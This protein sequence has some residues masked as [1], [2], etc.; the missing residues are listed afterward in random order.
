VGA[1][2][3][4]F[5]TFVGQQTAFYVDQP[6]TEIAGEAAE[7]TGRHHPATGHQDR[8]GIVATGIS[9]G[10]GAAAQLLRQRPIGHHLTGGYPSQGMPD[11]LLKIGSVKH[12]IDLPELAGIGEVSPQRGNHTAAGGAG[13]WS[14]RAARSA[15]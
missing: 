12:D 13:R 15:R 11:T 9:D 3:G 7:A 6:T 10:P 14:Q 2:C 8:Q 4:D 1:G 5:N